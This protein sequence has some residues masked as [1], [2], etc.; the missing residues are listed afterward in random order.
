MTEIVFLFAE[1]AHRAGPARDRV[2]LLQARRRPGAVRPCQGDRGGPDRR[3]PAATSPSCATSCSGPAPRWAAAGVA[4]QAIAAFDIALWDLKAKRAGLPLAK[5]LG[6]HRDSV[7]HL[8]HLRRLPARAD[9]AGQ[10]TR[11]RNR[12]PTASAA[13][14][15]RSGSRTDSIDLARVAR[16]TR[17]PR[18][19]RAADG[20]RQPAM[21]PAHRAARR[22]VRSSSS[23][24]CGSRSRSTPTT[25]RATR[26]WPRRWTPRSR[27]ARCCPA[28]A[29]TS[30]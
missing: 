25:P 17:A 5:L 6:A 28:S 23:T 21:G 2:Q 27:P 12:W 16:R 9:R 3:G 15:S 7:P 24:W 10:G 19:R 8:Q 13:S 4:T 11:H 22:A 26:S 29:S 30:G 20:R 1:I 18:R 14:R